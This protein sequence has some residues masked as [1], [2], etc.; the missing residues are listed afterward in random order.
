MNADVWP[1]VFIPLLSAIL[2][3]GITV[4]IKAR[5]KRREAESVQPF[6][7]R[8]VL[9]ESIAVVASVGSI[10]CFLFMILAAVGKVA[11]P[12]LVTPA[13]RSMFNSLYRGGTANDVSA[14]MADFAAGPVAW[15]VLALMSSVVAKL[16]FAL[17]QGLAERECRLRKRDNNLAA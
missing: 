16:S 10:G 12:P 2:L 11:G 8:H 5:K 9:L 17:T 15:L 1:W 14:L 3:A 13:V 4:G 6:Q 7:D